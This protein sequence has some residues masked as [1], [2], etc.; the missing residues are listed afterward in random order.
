M[1][2]N[3][4]FDFNNETLVSAEKPRYVPVG[5]REISAKLLRT[6]YCVMILVALLGI[7][8]NATELGLG[9]PSSDA[10]NLPTAALILQAILALVTAVALVARLGQTTNPTTD[11][12]EFGS[13][14]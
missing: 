13:K 7:A 8:A 5:H 11:F 4:N 12:F 14:P 3:F 9:T 6:Y 1:D 10:S 2:L